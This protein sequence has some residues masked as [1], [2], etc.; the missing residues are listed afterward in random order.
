[1]I[2][3]FRN[4][5]QRLLRESRFTR[6]LIYAIGEIILVVI[7]IL[8]ALGINS[9]YQDY[10]E[11]KNT[12]AILRQLQKELVTDIKDAKR[13]NDLYI[14][15]MSLAKD[16]LNDSL[17]I[18]ELMD[19]PNRGFFFTQ[20]VS[21]SYKTGS[22]NR[23]MQNTKVMPERYKVLLPF[24]DSIFVE[25]KNT[26]DDYNESIK[27]EVMR[28]ITD[29]FRLDSTEYRTALWKDPQ[30]NAG[31]LL[32]DPFFKNR[33]FLYNLKLRNMASVSNEYRYQ[34]I[35]LYKRIDSLLGNEKTTY[36]TLL[37]TLPDEDWTSEYEGDYVS[38]T[39][40]DILT[41]RFLKEKVR[42]GF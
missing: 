13:I 38:Q 14:K 29:A 1:M 25:T 10:K 17:T 6:Y 41:I 23:I 24:L 12:Q 28:T 2:K 27:E 37:R 22:Y 36:P 16:V 20:Y 35:S 42:L 19:D 31:D 11:D 9:T 30:K 5:R 3:F 7:G 4:I 18:D 8:I 26:I 39:E 40:R 15:N 33:V 32:N 34:A 21:F